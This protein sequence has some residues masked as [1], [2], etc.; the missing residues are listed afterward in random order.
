MDGHNQIP[1]LAQAAPN[2]DTELSQSTSDAESV[3][4]VEVAKGNVFIIHTDGTKVP[5]TIGAPIY[6]GDTL[7]T[8][9]DGSIGLVF[10]DNSTFSLAEEGSMVIDEMVYDPGS[11]EGNSVFSVAQGVFTFVSGEIAKTSVDAM[12]IKTPFTTIG[13]RGTSG[14]GKAGGESDANTFTLFADPDG[15]VGEATVS[16]Q[17]GTQVLSQ[18]NQ[19]TI[20]KSAFQTPSRP[21]V[22]PPSVVE[23]FYAKA[24]QALPPSPVQSPANQEGGETETPEQG[25]VEGEGTV[26]GEA[27]QAAEGEIQAEDQVEGPVEGL[28]E[29]PIEGEETALLAG[30]GGREGEG[31]VEG[32]APLGSEA[33]IIAGERPQNGPEGDGIEQAGFDAADQAARDAL[34]AGATQDQAIAIGQQ[35]AIDAAVHEARAQGITDAE[36]N[37]ATDA[38][39]QAIANGASLE[40]A[41][42]SAGNAA[43]TAGDTA[44]L[45][46]DQQQAQQPQQGFDQAGG[47]TN[48]SNGGT[49]TNGGGD[50][51]DTGDN[52]N[53]GSESNFG[54]QSPIDPIGFGSILS[55][56]P[57]FGPEQGDFIVGGFIQDSF[58]PEVDDG[59]VII[60]GDGGED[61]DGDGNSDGDPVINEFDD[62]IYNFTSGDDSRTGGNLNTRFEMAYD[63][64]GGNDDLFGN[65]GTD[66]IA[67]QDLQDVNT[68]LDITSTDMTITYAG[69]KSGSV[70]TDSVEQVYVGDGVNSKIRLSPESTED[71]GQGFLTVGTDGADTLT[72]ALGTTVGGTAVSAASLLGTIMFGRAGDD[73][74]IGSSGSDFLYGGDGDD[75]LQ[76]VASAD[77]GS[78]DDGDNYIGGNG[79]DVFWVIDPDAALYTDGNSNTHRSTFQGGRADGTDDS[80]GDELRLGNGGSGETYSLSASASDVEGIEVLDLQATASTVSGGGDF[81]AGLTTITSYTSGTLEVRT[82]D[83]GGASATLNLS[84]VDVDSDITT[85]QADTSTVSS[86]FIS[87]E[88]SGSDGRTITGSNGDDFILGYGGADEIYGGNGA[89]VLSGGSG[90]DVLSGGAGDDRLS[91]NSGDDTLDG[92]IGNDSLTG[93]GGADRFVFSGAGADSLGTDEITDFS[94]VF[95]FSS[96]ISAGEGDSFVL[97]TS[98][99]NI[100]SI[101]YEEVSW[102]GTTGSITLGNSQASVIVLYGVAGTLS[103]AM[104]ALA[105][106]NATG[107]ATSSDA[108]V[109]FNDSANGDTLT[110]AHTDDASTTATDVNEIATLTNN[111]DASLTDDLSASDFTVQA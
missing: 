72:H 100:N 77:T 86:V 39:E 87:D 23:K 91:S 63:D 108:I 4:K 52:G 48:L 35:A 85:L 105:N 41:F 49:D 94:G 70:F 81:F 107:D 20:I 3:G 80:T 69:S 16:T 43:E 8:D 99:L 32:E 15:T 73:T 102:D 42:F 56:D 21:V 29:G 65:G 44:A 1:E 5:A 12:T 61:D 62:F 104:A 83:G 11:Q 109:L 10:A 60:G 17:V 37:A 92:G 6:P 24:A 103:D 59:V 40:E 2:T 58:S 71:V 101:A 22:M 106:G 28:A 78:I 33:P 54:I 31:P 53:S 64:L 38:F 27:E 14:G 111:T 18:A 34:V 7:E 89:D 82:N 93:S 55:P 97:D 110:M 75:L 96:G 67:F 57:F 36:V 19:T 76:G 88:S 51:G 50:S 46:F 25:A 47:Q 68:V 66:E 84:G 45:Q 74:M 13:I 98:D 90:D 9:A 95:A 26:E 30:E 79:A